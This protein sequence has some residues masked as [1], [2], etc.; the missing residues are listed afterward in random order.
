MR[1]CRELGEARGEEVQPRGGVEGEPGRRFA[2]G[3]W[4]GRGSVFHT[5]ARVPI[6]D[7]QSRRLACSEL[8]SWSALLAPRPTQA[9]RCDPA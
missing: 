9:Q 6:T 2:E 3:T 8:R 1:G 5:G 4:A 7:T